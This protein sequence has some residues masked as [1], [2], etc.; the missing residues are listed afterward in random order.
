VS[1]LIEPE[2]LLRLNT[3]F[4]SED[5]IARLSELDERPS[6]TK[7]VEPTGTN[8]ELEKMGATATIALTID[9]DGTPKDLKIESASDP[10]FG[11]RCLE[12]AKQWRFKPATI[13]G[14]PVKTRVSLPFRL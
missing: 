5:R 9:R 1:G 10:D 6:P 3:T 13:K 14:V 12:A 7:T 8:R 4:R 11:R 2:K